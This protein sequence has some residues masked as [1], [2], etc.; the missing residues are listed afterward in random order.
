MRFTRIV[1]VYVILDI[2]ESKVDVQNAHIH[3]IMVRSKSNVFVRKIWIWWMVNVLVNAIMERSEL[4]V[5]VNAQK[6]N[7]KLME[8]AQIVESMVTI[9]QV[10]ASVR[11]IMNI[12]M[13]NVESSVQII[14]T[15][16]MA[17]V[18][19]GAL[20]NIRNTTKQ[21]ASVNVWM[22]MRR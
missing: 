15:F 13:V 12:L 16:R 5:Y 11:Q 18:L 2:I 9:N 4:M 17:N 21:Q 14:L 3:S 22:V 8:Y 1:C 6:E 20:N 10:P 7:I 19:R